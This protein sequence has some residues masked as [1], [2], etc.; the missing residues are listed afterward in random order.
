MYL[1]LQFLF[2]RVDIIQGSSVE[3]KHYGLCFLAKLTMSAKAF[4][5][6]LCPSSVYQS[7]R[8]FICL[9][10]CPSVC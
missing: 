7:V 3:Y 10:V 6:I 8:P 2:N 1:H 9:A 4:S 5:I